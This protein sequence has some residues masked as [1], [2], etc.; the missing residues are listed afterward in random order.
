M[1]RGPMVHH[2]PSFSP[3]DH[4]PS[5]LGGFGACF[6]FGLGFGGGGSSF[7]LG[8]GGSGASF[9]KLIPTP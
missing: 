1:R 2:R 8:F 7:D 3:L 5:T 6:G 4:L 9:L